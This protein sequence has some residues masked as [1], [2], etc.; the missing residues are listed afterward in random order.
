MRPFRNEG[1][2][3]EIG[4]GTIPNETVGKIQKSSYAKGFNSISLLGDVLYE[5]LQQINNYRNF[6]QRN[7]I[8]NVPAEQAMHTSPGTLLN[9]FE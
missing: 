9:P 8:M 2:R 7:F 6:A 4:S 5:I 1:S 3:T